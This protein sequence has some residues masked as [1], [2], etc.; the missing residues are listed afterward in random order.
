MA[1]PDVRRS[2][3]SS[4]APRPPRHEAVQFLA[5]M[6]L[7]F[8]V[9]CAVG[10]L[11]PI[12]NAFALDGLG[13]TEFYQTY[14]VSAIVVLFVPVFN[15]LADRF[16]WRWVVSGVA[17]FFA[18]NLLLFRAFYVSQ[19]A[20][21]GLLF[22]GWYDLFAAALVT[23]FFIA[24]QLFLNARTAKRAYPLV[25][26]GGSLGAS[27]GAAITGF[28]AVSVGTPNLLLVA[29]A[30]ILLFGAGIPLVWAIAAPPVP[31]RGAAHKAELSAG[32]L[33]ELAADPQVRLIA[34][35]VLVTRLVTQI[36][37][38][39]YNTVT[40][41]IFVELDAISAFQGKFDLAT[42]WLPIVVLAALRP[43]LQRWGVGLAVLLLPVS[44]VVTT[45]GLAAFWGLWA[46]V[47]ARGAERSF[48]YSAERAGREILYVPV[49]DA[50]KLKAKAYIDVAVE[51]GL[52]KALSA[53]LI[54][55]LL[56]VM[57]YRQIAYVGAAMSLGWLA[58]A[59]S[60]KRE[61]VRTLARSIEGRFASLRGSFASLLSAGIL[62]QVKGALASGDSLRTAFALDL[63]EQASPNDARALAGDVNA[64][65]GHPAEQIRERALNLLARYPE[66]VD[67]ARVRASLLDPVPDVREAAVRA[68]AAAHAER[69]GDLIRELLAA[70]QS[71]VRTATLACLARR[72]IGAGGDISKAVREI[73]ERRARADGDAG[74]RIESALAAAL[75][76]QDDRAA[77]ILE[78][79]LQDP[80]PR[81]RSAALHSAGLLGH[82]P[83]YPRMI[84]ALA[85]PATREAARQALIA[86]GARV[87][88]LLSDRLLD[89]R[90]DPVVRRTIPSVLA[91]IPS[92]DAVDLLL[93][94]VMA[95]ETE[96]FL[97]YRVLKALS[98]LRARH[99]DL[100]FPP[101]QVLAIL[102]REVAAAGG[103]AAA[104]A[105]LYALPSANGAV[106]LLCRALDESFAERREGIFRCLG[107]LYEPERVYRSYL[108][109][110]GGT[111]PARANALEWLEQTLGHAL[112]AR[113]APVIEPDRGAARRQDRGREEHLA[114]LRA[115]EDAWIARCALAVSLELAL[116]GVDRTDGESVMHLIEKVFLL[117]KVDLLQ[118]ARS[119]HLALLA[120]IAEETE[121]AAGTV[122]IRRGEPADALY[123]V[124]R[125]GVELHG[126][127]EHLLLEDDKAF[128]TWALIDDAP[129]PVEA[130][131][132]RTTHL[133]RIARADFQDLLADHS[134]LALGLLQGLA[135]RVRALVA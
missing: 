87:L 128:G 111:A 122:L 14:L 72:E 59:I 70:R 61:Y 44:M 56:Q 19:S 96:Q 105:A 33:R 53:V 134:D 63:V 4:P 92:Q 47:A 10:I 64:L 101:A 99:P 108:S 22:Y 45:T 88:P 39:E 13:A 30:F 20:T 112:F 2:T 97:D 55:L 117:Q 121:A 118:G 57:G 124:Q 93:R 38:Y 123:I 15:R 109:V 79:L 82:T 102:D 86:Q 1:S 110:T 107:L 42:N 65:T 120:S 36:V 80:E 34:A 135:R 71:E 9:V 43:G 78:P 90:A 37:D 73:L 67:E 127:G 95:R 125:G 75:L 114:A 17:V 7:F 89:T 6:A 18:A 98:K 83:A 24:T 91:G 130:R 131:A 84:D 26:T 50:I 35:T 126:V 40:K 11:R 27:L 49:P 133:L 77:R 115:D 68:L 60:V 106:A 23:Q 119:A 94:A 3:S 21:L 28:F 52:G 12:R 69:Q 100:V 85:S 41:E 8:L 129:S 104:R 103:H 81:V 46:A 58:L 51:K 29:A 132:V 16:P 5:M 76:P 113:I 31:P 48:R 54:F 66:A 62:P 74:A 25:I 32:S 116:P